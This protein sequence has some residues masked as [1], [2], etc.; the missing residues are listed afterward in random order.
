MKYIQSKSL[1]VNFNIVD[2][3]LTDWKK[4]MLPP[5]NFVFK[6]TIIAPTWRKAKISTRQI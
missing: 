2:R 4:E 1:R 6:V 3:Y 5:S